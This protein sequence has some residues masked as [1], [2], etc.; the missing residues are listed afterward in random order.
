MSTKGGFVGFFLFCLELEL[1][2]KTKKDLV[3]AQTRFINN[4][5]FKQNKKNPTHP[6]VD[7]GKD[8]NM[9]KISAK[10]INSMV[11]EI[12]Q[13]CLNLNL[14]IGFCLI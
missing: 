9:C 12:E 1:F 14:S 6:F 3:S 8:G 5:R 11:V 10:N 13:P 4:S 2:T 7:I